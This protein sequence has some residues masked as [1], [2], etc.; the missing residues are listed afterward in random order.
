MDKEDVCYLSML[1]PTEAPPGL[2]YDGLQACLMSDFFL[3]CLFLVSEFPYTV[4]H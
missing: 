2:S 3:C 4:R 1:N